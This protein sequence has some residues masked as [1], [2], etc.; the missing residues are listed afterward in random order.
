MS[1]KW[2]QASTPVKIAMV[3]VPTI[4][5]IG[6]I[7]LVYYFLTAE[8]SNAQLYAKGRSL[9]DTMTQ[10]YSHMELLRIKHLNVDSTEQE[11]ALLS[12]YPEMK[13]LSSVKRDMSLLKDMKDRLGCRIRR[14]A[15]KTGDPFLRQ[16]RLV[17][18]QSK[19]LLDVLEEL[20]TFWHSHSGY[21]TT[22]WLVADITKEYAQL[23]QNVIDP[24]HVKRII[25]AAA[26]GGPSYP[27][28]SFADK[29]KK[30]IAM[31]AQCQKTALCYPLLY[32]QVE[33]LHNELGILLGTIA[34]LPDYATEL[35]IKKQH[36]LEQERIAIERQKAT[37]MQ[38]QAEAAQAKANAMYQQA[39]AERENKSAIQKSSTPSRT[40]I[41]ITVQS[42]SH[43]PSAHQSEPL[44]DPL[45]E[46][47]EAIPKGVYRGWHTAMKWKIN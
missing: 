3:G 6:G 11:L 36:E 18:A 20:D 7:G 2:M 38:K 15:Y 34:S 45:A 47:N 26:V 4:I 28:V 22:S 37:A 19:Q 32:K 33:L 16:M 8:E 30:S 17:F 39:A 35:Q 29:L 10:R 23:L 42:P 25:M 13:V 14:D 27:Y 41:N 46:N 5:G 9:C 31:V 12:S 40:D 1:D 44:Y 21:F 24:N 43:T